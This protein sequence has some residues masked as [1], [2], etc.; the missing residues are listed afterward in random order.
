MSNKLVSEA[1][2]LSVL[3]SI[4]GRDSS[5]PIEPKEI[6][7]KAQIRANKSNE[8]RVRNAIW[9]LRDSG[10]LIAL[11]TKER[12][13]DSPSG[14]YIADSTNDLLYEAHVIE[15]TIKT[16]AKHLSTLK[17][18]LSK[19]DPEKCS[20]KSDT[21]VSNSAPSVTTVIDTSGAPLPA[22]CVRRAL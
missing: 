13:K 19:G 10:Y 18:I 16:K 2:K 11:K 20:Q 6:C 15:E 4:R 14:F 5:T 9:I 12:E 17:K 7:K 3:A 1:L 22:D 21:S 8:E